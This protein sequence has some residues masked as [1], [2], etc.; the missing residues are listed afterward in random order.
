M[1][2]HEDDLRA[3]AQDLFVGE[4]EQQEQERLH[5]SGRTMAVDDGPEEEEAR[6]NSSQRY[7]M[8]ETDDEAVLFTEDFFI[9]LMEEIS[10]ELGPSWHKQDDDSNS[11][12]GKHGR[13]RSA[14]TDSPSTAASTF[15]DYADLDDD[16]DGFAFPDPG[17]ELDFADDGQDDFLLCIFCR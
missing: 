11:N 16:L 2:G 3:C 17:E 15:G 13:A 6:G 1:Q 9:Q 5:P 4:L 7:I 12:Q 10:S 14:I 8:D